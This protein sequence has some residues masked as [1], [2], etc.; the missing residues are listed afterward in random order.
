[1]LGK[2]SCIVSCPI[3]TRSGYGSR[4][5][6]FVKSLIA[7][8]KDDWDIKILPQRWGACPWGALDTSNPVD[9]DIYD[10]MISPFEVKQQPDIWIQITVPNEM[11]KMGKFN[12]LVTAGVETTIMPVDCING[13]NNADLIIVS[14]NHVKK[15]FENTF[16]DRKDNKTNQIIEKIKLNKPV[17][18]LFEGVDTNIFRK[19]ELEHLAELADEDPSFHVISYELLNIHEEFCFLS[20][21]HLLPG[22]LGHDRKQLTTLIK[23]FL[24]TFKNRKHKPALILKT[25]VG[26][27]SIVEEENLL[28]RIDAIRKQVKG[29]LP[30]IYVIHGDLSDFEMNLLYNNRKVKAFV[31]T[32]NEGFGRP[33]L[34]FSAASSKPIICS[35]WSGHIDFLSEEF[36]VYVGG[37]LDNVHPSAANQFLLQEAQ[38]FIVDPHQLSIA[39]RDMHENYKDY[40]DKGKRQGYRS[41]TQF[42]L[43]QMT[44]KLDEILKK[45]MPVISRPMTITLPK[46]ANL[47]DE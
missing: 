41:R 38:W 4:S 16:F 23:V 33:Y 34:E 7:V 22:D 2:L 8:K 28:D 15:I 10:R 18:V 39:L 35:P 21:G 46:L 20:V 14:S 5:R 43:I 11:M 30:N 13:A 47:I 36:N 6:D 37:K 42:S 45:H 17:E 25:S 27:C 40:L 44:N 19:F 24:E 3:D 26:G 29:D 31:L 9:K 32:G 12:I 1:M